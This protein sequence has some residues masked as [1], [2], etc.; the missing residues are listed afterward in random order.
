MT[1]GFIAL[2]RQIQLLEAA[3]YFAILSQLSKFCMC[4]VVKEFVFVIRE[5]RLSLR[6]IFINPMW[7]L[8][9]ATS[10]GVS[11]LSL[12]SVLFK[13]RSVWTI[14]NHQE[15]TFW[16]L[17]A[18]FRPLKQFENLTWIYKVFMIGLSSFYDLVQHFKTYRLV[19][20]LLLS[21]R[22]LCE[23][24][25]ASSIL[26]CTMP[27]AHVSFTSI[28]SIQESTNYLKRNNIVLVCNRMEEAV[29][30]GAVQLYPLTFLATF[31]M[32]VYHQAPSDT[33]NHG[34][35]TGVHQVC[36]SF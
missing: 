7:S 28:N 30:I 22:S 19:L 3:H 9:T 4:D 17:L 26:C 6:G 14:S 29:I 12:Q 8:T 5:T 33:V 10:K 24:L 21:L 27:A 25:F 2:R 16:K 23:I 31:T 1:R 32:K 34:P 18:D 11:T 15:S 35:E 13:I 36:L 20:V